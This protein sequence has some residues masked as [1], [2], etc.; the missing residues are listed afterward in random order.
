MAHKAL[1][2]WPARKISLN[3]NLILLSFK[4]FIEDVKFLFQLFLYFELAGFKG[5]EFECKIVT[6][7]TKLRYSKVSLHQFIII[8]AREGFLKDKSLSTIDL[9]KLDQLQNKLDFRNI[10]AK[11][12]SAFLK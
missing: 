1:L 10:N 2:E 4:R 8:V 12:L 6:Y 9:S 5:G 11:I 3:K 7:L